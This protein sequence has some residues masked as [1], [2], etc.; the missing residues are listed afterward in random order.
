MRKSSRGQIANFKN[1]KVTFRVR[2]SSSN[3]NFKCFLKL[4]FFGS[5]SDEQT[6]VSK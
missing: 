4:S 5:S 3:N 2:H 6:G 1:E